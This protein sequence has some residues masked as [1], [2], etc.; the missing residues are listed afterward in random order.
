[1]SEKSEKPETYTAMRSHIRSST[2]EMVLRGT[3]FEPTAE[4]IKSYKGAEHLAVPS[5]TRDAKK[6]AEPEDEGAGA[7]GKT[8]GK[9][10][11]KSGAK[12]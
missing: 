1:M 12:D 2:N 4:E 11:G 9:A 6:V 8:S 7:G 5:S 10:G 3:R